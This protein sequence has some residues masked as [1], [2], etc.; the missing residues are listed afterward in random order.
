MATAKMFTVDRYTIFSVQ[1][2]W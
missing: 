2:Y 1:L